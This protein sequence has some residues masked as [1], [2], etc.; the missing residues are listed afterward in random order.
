MANETNQ[1][2]SAYSPEECRNMLKLLINK[3]MSTQGVLTALGLIVVV[4]IASTGFI[5]SSY[6]KAQEH[7]D[8]GILR[9]TQKAVVSE[10]ERAVQGEKLKNIE[11]NIED[12]KQAQEIQST[13]MNNLLNVMEEIDRKIHDHNGD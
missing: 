6:S 4:A 8:K 10:K 9:N 11:R 1:E 2:K 5:I 12:I 7:Q 3:K 13:T